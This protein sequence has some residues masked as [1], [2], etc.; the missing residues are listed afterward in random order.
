VQ[1]ATAQGVGPTTTMLWLRLIE[2][3]M[4]I[5]SSK[6]Q[7]RAETPGAI[8]GVIRN[9]CRAG[10]LFALV[11]PFP[12]NVAEV[13]SIESNRGLVYVGISAASASEAHGF[14]QHNEVSHDG[15]A[16]RRLR[17]TGT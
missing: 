17:Q 7:R 4:P 12:Q 15:R 14:W 2:G 6:D 1:D 10:H 9:V 13:I 16:D 8:A 5:K 11:S 3:Q